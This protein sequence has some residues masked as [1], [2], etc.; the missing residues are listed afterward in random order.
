MT[1]DSYSGEGEIEVLPA[2]R[3]PQAQALGQLHEQAV[4]LVEARQM[5]EVLADPTNE[6]CPA[7]YRGKLGSATAAILYGA[8]L[9]LNAT[10]SLQQVFVVHGMPAIYAR[11]AVAL[12]KRAGIV[13]ETVSSTDDAVTVK[14]TDRTTGQVETS[15]WDTGRSERAGY[16]TNKKYKT[17][18]QAM[19]WAKAA[20]ECCRRIAPDVLL[21]IP[22]SREELDLESQPVQVKSTR[23]KGVAGLSAMIGGPGTGLPDEANEVASESGAKPEP[24]QVNE[25]VEPTPETDVAYASGEQLRA[26]AMLRRAEGHG[27]DDEG[28]ASWFTWLANVIGREVESNKRLTSDEA[29]D[30]IAM[31]EHAHSKRANNGEAEQQ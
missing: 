25:P 31:L 19:H 28:R 9:G 6:L 26:L 17:D 2:R 18:P 29:G 27:D 22:M 23:G 30:I 7:L 4:A 11:T 15:T 24:S 14:A 20:M 1:V 8:E 10:Q 13:V 5:A 16:H 3:P 12:C 21:G